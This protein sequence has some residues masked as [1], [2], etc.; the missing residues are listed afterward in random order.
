MHWTGSTVYIWLTVWKQYRRIKI[1]FYSSRKIKA[2]P[3]RIEH[4]IQNVHSFS[5]FFFSS[6]AFPLPFHPLLFL[7]LFLFFLFLTF[8]SFSLMFSFILST[9]TPLTLSSSSSSI[10]SSFYPSK[11]FTLV[12]SCC[13]SFSLP[14]SS[15]FSPPSSGLLLL[16][17]NPRPP[18][19]P[20]RRTG[21]QNLMSYFASSSP[22]FSSISAVVTCLCRQY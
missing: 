4:T 21:E 12:T 1:C 18:P 20:L 6:R 11:P 7:L 17:P 22:L 3:E 16:P 8:S 19:P 15:P 13:P 2:I 14:Y 10:S 9:H 5:S